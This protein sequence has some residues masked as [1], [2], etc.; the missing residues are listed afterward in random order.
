MEPNI[1]QSLS[2]CPLFQGIDMA[3]IE[4]ILQDV[5]FKLVRYDKKDIYTLAGMP[6][7]YADIV[8]KGELTT[9]M[10][11]MSG[12]TVEVSRLNKG[13]IIAPA[14]I[15]AKDRT[16]PVS[17]ET[18]C[19]TFIL[20]FQPSEFETLIDHDIRLRRNFIQILSNIDVFLTK[21]MRVLSLFTVREKV[22]YFLTDT[23]KKQ[24]S[25]TIL[26]DKS[27]QEIAESFGIQKFSLLRCFSELVEQ[28]AIEVN[29]KQITIIDEKK[30]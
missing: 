14:F 26:L 19:E 10:V 27:R 13:D 11:S 3:E 30:F 17:V 15:F 23:A 28:G 2:I 9:R 1:Y 12:K 24:G 20:R 25:R 6:C 29:G 5:S 16:M 18:E 8:I 7:K 4:V 21:K 22:A